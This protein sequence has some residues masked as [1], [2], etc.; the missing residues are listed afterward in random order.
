MIRKCMDT[1]IRE[2]VAIINDAA[3]AYKG[4]IPDD[5]CHDPYMPMDEI[6]RLLKTYWNIPDR[7]V[8]TSVVL[9]DMRWV[10]QATG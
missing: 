10:S 3:Q 5:R 6:E 1:D 8:V 9:A 2:M 4:V 7:Q